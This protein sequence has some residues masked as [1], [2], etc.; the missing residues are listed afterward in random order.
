MKMYDSLF[1]LLGNYTNK[2]YTC[3]N[4]ETTVEKSIEV[5]IK[6]EICKIFDYLIDWREEFYLDKIMKYF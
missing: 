2:T 5:K 4:E 6:L 3:K 1:K